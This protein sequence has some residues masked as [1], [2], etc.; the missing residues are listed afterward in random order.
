MEI[1]K[2]KIDKV[3]EISEKLDKKDEEINVEQSKALMNA[4]RKIKYKGQFVDEKVLWDEIKYAG[5]SG[6]AGKLLKE[7]YPTL[8]KVAE[9]QGL[10]AKELSEFCQVELG[11]DFKQVKITDIIKL[12]LS[13]IDYKNK[14]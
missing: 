1:T 10:L 2:E 7:K 11:I 3:F 13:L 5:V 8:F 9:E 6:D 4:Q 12:C 14:K